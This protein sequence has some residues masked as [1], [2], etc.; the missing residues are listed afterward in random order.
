M[1]KR[2]PFYAQL[3]AMDCGPAALR[4]VCAYYGR[5][6]SQAWLRDLCQIGRGGV[7]LLGMS[8]AAEKIGLRALPVRLPFKRLR[9]EAPMPCIAHWQGDHFVV[10]YEIT[11]KKVRVS[12]PAYGLIDY[13]HEEFIRASAPPDTPL[14]ETSPGIYLLVETTP[15]FYERSASGREDEEPEARGI[16]FFFSYLRPHQRLLVQVLLGMLVGLVLELILP[17]LAQATV[18]RGIGNLDMEFIYVL[19]GAQL[20]LSLSQTG[21]D[22]IRSWL[23]LHIGSRV[24]IAMIADFLHKLL[25]L[26]L[27]FFD[28]RT[29]GDLMQR[30][31]DHRRVKSFL[32]SSSLD[33]IFSILSMFVFAFVLSL[34]SWQIL[35]V[36]VVLTALSVGWLALFLKRRQVLD[37]KRFTLEAKERDTLFE[38]IHAMPE[39]KIQGIQRDKRWDWEQ[40]AVRTYRLE[41]QSLAL[42]QLQRIGVFLISNLRNILISF[43]A[44]RSVINGEM[45]LGMM[46]ATQYI[47]GQ[48]NSP[49]GRLIDFLYTA[50]DA[51]LSLERMQEIYRHRDEQP[52]TGEP[53]V[54]E[55]PHYD[56]LRLKDLSFRYPGAGQ[57]EVLRGVD[58]TIPVGK[59]TAIVGASG[60]GKTTMLK[61]LLGLYKPTAGD[62]FVGQVPLSIIEKRLWTSRCGVVM[63]DGYI[64]SGSIARNIAPGSAAINP[65][66]LDFALRLASLEEYIR[67]LPHGANTLVGAEGQGL[68]GGQ[69]QRVLLARAIY[70]D[71]DFL[72]LDEATSSLDANNESTVLANLR[73]FA[74]G[75][76]LVV[77]AHRL[78]TVRDAD[79]IV[80]LDQ[81][82]IIEVGNHE[83]LIAQAGAYYRLVRNQLQLETTA[84]LPAP[85]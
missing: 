61:L 69:K 52:V 22:M 75:R 76:T 1:S 30:I 34:Y 65:M 41:S 55:L 33:I 26:P 25:R 67:S 21:A 14:S 66:L 48:L 51:K 45:T 85:E 37:Y 82:R 12:D 11:R 79:Q 71:P 49:I 15:E 74:V 83:S 18:D 42:R 20:V 27:P 43:L 78:S 64:F 57:A 16:S 56:S 47:V 7:N 13:T 72:F 29:A 68:S 77:I 70:R 44:A 35:A 10:V 4:M 53:L 3:D 2:F 8:E 19:L 73:E 9:D 46:L 60:S 84:A 31:S 6:F 58:L 36:F 23:L 28:S 38:I 5:E 17:F 40:L 39:I 54:E 32:M 80:V 81:G 24:S 59:V 50:Q 62:I 63:Q